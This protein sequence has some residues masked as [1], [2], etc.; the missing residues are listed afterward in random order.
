MRIISII[1]LALITSSCN[2]TKNI[3]EKS[4]L[5]ELTIENRNLNRLIV[6]RTPDYG[7]S[8]LD[9]CIVMNG[10]SMEITELKN[11]QL[12]SGKV[13]DAKTEQPLVNAGLMLTI[14]QNGLTTT[15]EI[16][17]DGNGN[18]RT[19]LD[20]EL[21]HILVVKVAYRTLKIDLNKL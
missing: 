19:E 8:G 18:F 17:S 2:G 15:N 12:I 13:F 1:L 14:I 7:Y 21:E 11:D 20:G 10:I 5:S 3:S 9:G 4:K 16:L 6:D